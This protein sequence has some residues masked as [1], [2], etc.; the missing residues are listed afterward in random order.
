MLYLRQFV[1]SK[2]TENS[3]KQGELIMFWNLYKIVFFVS[4]GI[5]CVCGVLFNALPQYQ[6]TLSVIAQLSLFIGI[7]PLLPIIITYAVMTIYGHC[8]AMAD[9]PKA[10]NW[11]HIFT[12]PGGIGL[13]L[14]M[15]MD[16][17]DVV[18]AHQE[19]DIHLVVIWAVVTFGLL[20]LGW[21]IN[22]VPTSNRIVRDWSRYEEN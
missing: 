10:R 11:G 17:P 2:S 7:G 22:H 12:F 13:I 18:R 15:C 16:G 1:T 8:E 14:L 21:F 20:G 19:T 4:M 6:S 3:G 9:W 5:A